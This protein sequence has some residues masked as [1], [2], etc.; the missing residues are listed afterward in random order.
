[1]VAPTSTLSL[2]LSISH[3]SLLKANSADLLPENDGCSLEGRCSGDRS[4]E[5]YESGLDLIRQRF[6]DYNYFDFDF[7]F[8]IIYLIIIYF[9]NYHTCL[10][11]CSVHHL[12]WE[13]CVGYCS[14]FINNRL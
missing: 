6:S 8:Q 2:S 11:L 12:D 5:I 1:M 14:S 7:D 13:W 4:R 9:H 10:V 3:V